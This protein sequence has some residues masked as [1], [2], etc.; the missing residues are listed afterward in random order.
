MERAV[1]ISISDARL[2]D[3][4]LGN[5]KILGEYDVAALVRLSKLKVNIRR[6]IDK[7]DEIEREGRERRM[8]A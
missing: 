2:I 3:E 1:A 8:T 7:A 4:L 6:L 5:E